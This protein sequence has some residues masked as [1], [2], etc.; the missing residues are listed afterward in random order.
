MSLHLPLVVGA[1]SQ[2]GEAAEYLPM[3]H[4]MA[5][6]RMPPVSRLD[7]GAGTAEA[8][9]I[10]RALHDEM[11]AWRFGTGEQPILVLTG[12]AERNPGALAFINESLGQGEVSAVIDGTQRVA[13]Q[14][15]AFA[16]VWRVQ[17]LDEQGTVLV[18]TLEVGP[19]PEVVRERAMASARAAEVVEIGAPPEGYMNSP[20]IL[21]EL[22]SA[23][24]RFRPGQAAH[25]VN[26]TLLPVTPEDHLHLETTLGIGSTTILSRGYGNC[27]ISATALSNVWWVRYFNSMD[28]LI[29]DTIEVVDVPQAAL[30]AREDFEDS[31]ERLEQL[32]A[33]LAEP[34][35]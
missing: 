10:L 31:T 33:I 18:D 12:L 7:G 5:T 29:L 24:A 20:S 8:C 17:H 25:V 9:A 4:E 3:P 26:L 28:T 21:H 27:R 2:E 6:F 16:S 34:E 35:A 19:I 1:G 22:V 13:I 14:E 30:A 32:L 15:T 23:S 11:T